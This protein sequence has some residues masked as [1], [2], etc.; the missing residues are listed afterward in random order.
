[1]TT[2]Y[3]EE[4]MLVLICISDLL[5]VRKSRTIANWIVGAA[6]T[7]VCTSRSSFTRTIAINSGRA[8]ALHRVVALTNPS[9][10]GKYISAP[11]ERS[12]LRPL[13][14]G[15]EGASSEKALTRLGTKIPTLQRK[16][17]AIV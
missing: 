11:W 13:S 6:S 2:G 3:S 12:G 1:M 4:G 7:V 14:D 9:E 16:E 17:N 5:R 8:V 15:L 10:P